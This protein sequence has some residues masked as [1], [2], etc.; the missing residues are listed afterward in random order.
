M[1]CPE[2]YN[3]YDYCTGGKTGYTDQVRTKMVTMADNGNMQLVAVLL[4]DDGDVYAD[5]RAMFDYVF[6]NFSKVRLKDKAKAEGV[7]S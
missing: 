5:T 7:S 6:S 2:I 4:Q 3:Y 1:L